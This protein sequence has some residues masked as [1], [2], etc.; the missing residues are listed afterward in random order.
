MT[1]QTLTLADF[2]AARI[3]EDERSS[4]WGRLHDD[5]HDP[6]G[7]TKILRWDDGRVRTECEAKRRI[8][9]DHDDQ[10]D[11]PGWADASAFPYVGCSVLRN[12][13]MPYADHPDFREE[14]RA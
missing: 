1:A 10:H 13:A 14:W 8:V 2:L 4:R 7:L 12:L 6:D 5:P 11:C 9:A 3:A